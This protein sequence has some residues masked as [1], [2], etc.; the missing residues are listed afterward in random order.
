VPVRGGLGFLRGHRTAADV[1][2]HPGMVLC[3]LADV[4]IAH[5]VEAAVAHLHGKEV[6]IT[7]HDG[8]EGRP[9][10][11]AAGNAPGHL[12][13]VG[14]RL[15]LLIH[16]CP[17]PSSGVGSAKSPVAGGAGAASGSAAASAGGAS[18]AGPPSAAAAA[19]APA[20]RRV[21]LVLPAW[22]VTPSATT[23]SSPWIS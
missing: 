1:L 10:A 14:V 15:L 6:V 22:N 20:A 18:S 16:H 9:H 21:S 3:D 2:G 12:D 13:D 17:L 23:R 19:A 5:Q 4:A 11:A 8:G 7:D